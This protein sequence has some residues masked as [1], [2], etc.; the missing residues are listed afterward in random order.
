MKKVIFFIIIFI[1]ISY[2]LFAHEIILGSNINDIN[3][4]DYN[5]YNYL[6]YNCF[7][8][9]NIDDNKNINKIIYGFGF[10]LTEEDRERLFNNLS[11]LLFSKNYNLFEIDED[12]YSGYYYFRKQESENIICL[13]HWF[14]FQ[15]CSNTSLFILIEYKFEK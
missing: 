14:I 4:F 13:F 10:E 3:D 11:G 2:S 15:G 12:Q 6:G 1:S 9:I 5:N 8:R 7:V